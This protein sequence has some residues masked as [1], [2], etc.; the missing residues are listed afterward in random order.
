[1]N[2]FWSARVGGNHRALATWSG[3]TIEW[4]WIGSHDEYESLVSWQLCGHGMGC[5]AFMPESPIKAVYRQ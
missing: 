4:F 3:N 5:A 1:V 2:D